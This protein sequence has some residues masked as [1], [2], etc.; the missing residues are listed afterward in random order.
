MQFARREELKTYFR[1]D[2]TERKD[3]PPPVPPEA[4][5]QGLDHRQAR[6]LSAAK[7]KGGQTPEE[8]D[9]AASNSNT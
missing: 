4:L 9:F 3:L 1:Q 8:G 5:S 2:D 7:L 6:G